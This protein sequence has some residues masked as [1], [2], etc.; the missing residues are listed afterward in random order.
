LNHRDARRLQVRK[1]HVIALLEKNQC[2]FAALAALHRDWF[3]LIA[4]EKAR[5]LSKQTTGYRGQVRHKATT[6]AH[7]CNEPKH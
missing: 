6:S 7:L 2:L 5:P 4:Y 3:N 1:E